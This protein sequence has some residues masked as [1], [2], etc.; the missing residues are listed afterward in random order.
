MKLDKIPPW[1]WILVFLTIHSKK[2]LLQVVQMIFVA[3]YVNF[4]SNWKGSKIPVT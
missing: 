4:C 2:I 1:K 3:V